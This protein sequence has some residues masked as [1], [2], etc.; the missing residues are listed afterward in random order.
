M[1]GIMATTISK[2]KWPV[3]VATVV[4]GPVEMLPAT[5]AEV[6]LV[7]VGRTVAPKC[8]VDVDGL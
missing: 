5:V 3:S 1:L 7:W 4:G 6:D 8:V 2:L